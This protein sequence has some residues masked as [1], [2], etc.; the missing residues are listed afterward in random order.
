M[1]VVTDKNEVLIESHITNSRAHPRI[2]R[3]ILNCTSIAV[4]D[5][6]MRMRADQGGPLMLADPMCLLQAF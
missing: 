4:L 2:V 6:A 3:R 1:V 5:L